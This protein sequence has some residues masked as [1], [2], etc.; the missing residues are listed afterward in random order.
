MIPVLSLYIICEYHVYTFYVFTSI[1]MLCIYIILCIM[2]MYFIYLHFM[3][4]L[5]Y[6]YH[7]DR[8]VMGTHPQSGLIYSF[9]KME[10]SMFHPLNWDL[11]SLHQDVKR[12]H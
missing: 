12:K 2:C 9:E 4:L 11:Y 10:R 5:I 1:H 3:Y 6:L 8:Y 7:V